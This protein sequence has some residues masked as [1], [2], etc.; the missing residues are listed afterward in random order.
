MFNKIRIYI[1]GITAFTLIGTA[2]VGCGANNPA[3]AAPEDV[4]DSSSSYPAHFLSYNNRTYFA[5]GPVLWSPDQIGDQIGVASQHAWESDE[6]PY[7]E[8]EFPGGTPLFEI[9]GIDSGIGFAAL[10]GEKYS[11]MCVDQFECKDYHFEP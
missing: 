3:A 8:I 11:F 4:P 7:G 1:I 2:I 5:F 6:K 9:V 10:V